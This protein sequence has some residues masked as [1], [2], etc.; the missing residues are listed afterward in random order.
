MENKITSETTVREYTNDSVVESYA[1]AVDKV[2][3]WESEK[4]LTDRVFDAC[5]FSFN[6]LM[7]IRRFESVII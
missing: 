1:D 3:L 6:R 5:I 2:G 4:H 7:T